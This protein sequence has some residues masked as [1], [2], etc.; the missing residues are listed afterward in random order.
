MSSSQGPKT[1]QPGFGGTLSGFKLIFFLSTA[2]QQKKPSGGLILI[3]KLAKI[4]RFPTA[5]KDF[6]YLPESSYYFYHYCFDLFSCEKAE[7]IRLGGKDEV[8]NGDA[9]V[10]SVGIGNR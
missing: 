6:F 10:P 4:G 1:R 7:V 2:P 3:C 8:G 9:G 5:F